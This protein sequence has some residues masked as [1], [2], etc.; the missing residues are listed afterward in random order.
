MQIMKI[1]ISVNDKELLIFD[2]LL[3]IIL[4]LAYFFYLSIQ[5]FYNLDETQDFTK[6]LTTTTENDINLEDLKNEDK[7]TS[8]LPV[9]QNESES[10]KLKE[11]SVAEKK[12]IDSKLEKQQEIKQPKKE[13]EWMVVR[14]GK[15]VK[16][17][18]Q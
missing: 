18:N 12:K 8:E 2:I 14:K 5:T 10:T 6:S 15:K 11:N 17:K 13:E 9:E 1:T 16:S 3:P 7:D 4:I